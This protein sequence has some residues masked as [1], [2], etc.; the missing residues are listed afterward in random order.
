MTPSTHARRPVVARAV[1][2]A[3]RS[4]V[5]TQVHATLVARRGRAT[6]Y[7]VKLAAC[8][9]SVFASRAGHADQWCMSGG[10][11][12]DGGTLARSVTVPASAEPR[13]I[14][15]V[16]VRVVASHP[17]VGDLKARLVH[18]SG[19]SVQLLDRPGMPSAGYPGPW[20]CGGDNLDLWFADD[21]SSCAESSCP[22]AVTPVLS[23]SQ[24]P[25][26][27]LAALLGR[28]PAGVWTLELQ[29]AVPGD[30]GSAS[31]LCLELVT[32]PDCNLNGVS[33]LSD[34][35]TGT[36]LD[37]N[38]DGVPDE[39]GC[40]ADLTGDGIVGGADLAQALSRW[41]SCA[42]ACPEDLTGDGAVAA[43]DLAL[44]LSSWGRVCIDG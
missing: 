13:T 11:I 35:S 10:T 39:C 21:A 41:G 34:I 28:A 30:A 9:A 24:R 40:N 38:G 32:A 4:T 42:I 23:G 44:V 15:S 1:R 6:A 22:Y 26:G 18:P 25:S 8:I 3:P 5:C 29:D 14:L 31:I 19:L 7:A 33:D 2:D 12:P 17:W 27:P 43:D 37:Q 20:G 36:S 16:R